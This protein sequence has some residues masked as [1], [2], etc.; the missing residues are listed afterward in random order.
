MD[1]NKSRIDNSFGLFFK[2]YFSKK[3]VKVFTIISDGHIF[4]L[5]YAVVLS[6]ND[7]LFKLL[8]N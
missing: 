8:S 2:V 7:V 3:K 4:L 6:F 1:S 5:M